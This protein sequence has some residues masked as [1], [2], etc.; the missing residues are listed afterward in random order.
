MDEFARE[1]VVPDEPATAREDLRVGRVLPD[2]AT[3]P[4]TLREGLRV[5]T[6]LPDRATEPASAMEPQ[7][8]IQPSLPT[9]T[10]VS[11]SAGSGFRVT[12]DQYA[13][14]AGP[15]LAV[16]DQLSELYSSLNGFLS[17]L[18]TPWG[19]DHAGHQFADGDQGYIKYSADTLTGLQTLPEGL[20][21]VAEGMKAMAQNYSSV[22]E[23]I[24]SGMTDQDA[25][26]QSSQGTYWSPTSFSAALPRTESVARLTTER[27]NTSGRH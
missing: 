23:A 14:A 6:V 26:L 25:E 8:A 1:W 15:L 3:E 7:T 19:D 22:E 4:A 20:R 17:G 27:G 24:A 21:N 2:S 16:A 13:A 9:Q 18:Q 10:G 12:A 11:G 5:G